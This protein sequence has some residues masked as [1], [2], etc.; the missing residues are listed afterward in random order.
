MKTEKI[1][2][3]ISPELKEKFKS[4]CEKKRRGMSSI[5][6]ELIEKYVNDDETQKK[7]LSDTIDN[8]YQ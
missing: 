4:I 1:I 3:V 8:Y 7:L 5:I 2:F 6:T